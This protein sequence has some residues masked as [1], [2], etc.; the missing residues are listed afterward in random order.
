MNLHQYRILLFLTSLLF[1]TPNIGKSQE[2]ISPSLQFQYFKNSDDQRLLKATLTFTLK[3]KEIP[4]VGQEVAFYS[5]S[6]KVLLAKVN[7]DA[8][9]VASL[10]L[11]N[12]YQLPLEK[13]GTWALSSEYVGKDSIGAASS[14]LSVKDFHLEMSL[15]LVDSVKTVSLKAYTT[16][17]GKKVPV[18]GEAI[19]IYVARTFCLLP[20]T[21]GTF[22]EDGTVN[23]EFPSDVP[24]DKEGN[25]TVVAKF[26]DHP[27]FGNVEKRSSAQWGVP[28]KY[29]EPTTHRALWTKGAPT[30]MI[31][32]LTIMLAGVWGHYTYAIICL[33]RIK[34]SSND[35]EKLLKV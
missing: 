9:G 34:K 30:W 33:I 31:V 29:T 27:T 18:S 24:G 1:V 32:A 21:D 35:D 26:D 10:T 28:S 17:N 25:L 14:E 3:R 19:N 16:D 12:D 8:N 5:G 20:I 6:K 22:G 2:S 15:G 13:D 11:A 23:L 4:I 7:T